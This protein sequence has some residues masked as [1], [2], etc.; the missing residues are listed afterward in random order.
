MQGDRQIAT[1]VHL[2]KNRFGLL[3]AVERLLQFSDV[4]QYLAQTALRNGDPARV[5]Q[6]PTQRDPLLITLAGERIVSFLEYRPSQVRQC[7][8]SIGNEVGLSTKSQ[9][10]FQAGYRFVISPHIPING[11]KIAQYD[12]NLPLVS[13]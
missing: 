9:A 4:H 8:G 6:L 1:V 7:N 2:S 11:A 10:L 13:Q 5:P 3:E 12:G